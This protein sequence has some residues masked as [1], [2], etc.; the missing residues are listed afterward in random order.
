MNISRRE[1]VPN[2]SDESLSI[3]DPANILRRGKGRGWAEVDFIAIDAQVYRAR[4]EVYRSREKATGRLQRP[5]RTLIKV[6]DASIVAATRHSAMLPPHPSEVML[7]RRA[8]RS[9]ALAL[10]VE[11]I[12]Y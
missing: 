3:S 4:W 10:V 9:G 7:I 1:Q 8:I 5:L 11:I 6:A 2:A 12:C